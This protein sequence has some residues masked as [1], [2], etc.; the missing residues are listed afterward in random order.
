MLH[1]HAE[2]QYLLGESFRHVL[3]YLVTHPIIGC[4]LLLALY[5][6]ILGI[7]HKLY[8]KADYDMYLFAVVILAIVVMV[9][10]A[11]YTFTHVPGFHFGG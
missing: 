8:G 3:S 9:G 5:G 11:A 10:S 1:V 7:L 2:P 6:V 4:A